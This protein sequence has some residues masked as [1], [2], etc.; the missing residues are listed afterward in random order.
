MGIFSRIF[1]ALFVIVAIPYYWLLI[2]ARTASVPAR[3]I[4][5]GAIRRAAAQ[6]DGARPTAI[7]FAPVAVRNMPGTVLVAGGGLR[8]DAVA[9]LAF[10]LATPGGDT[11]IDAGPTE[12]QAEDLGFDAFN[13]SARKAV[14]RWM[15]GARR[16]V[17]THEHPEFVGAFLTSPD[18]DA[19]APKAVLNRTQAETM[20]RMRRGTLGHVG[21]IVDPNRIVAVAP[22]IVLI[23]A[24][25]HSRGSQLIYVQLANG[26]EYLFVGDTASMRR[27]VTWQRPRSRL[28]SSWQGG[29]DRDAVIG[30][31]KGLAALQLREPQLT[32][33]YGSDLAW[34]QSP[35]HG[36]RFASAFR[37]VGGDVVPHEEDPTAAMPF[38]SNK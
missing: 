10:R 17:F 16:I 24:P 36:P 30:W 14:D 29:E 38:D 34:L 35:T 13:P 23:P 20:D 37:Y 4:D 28:A 5:I 19:I 11:I 22:G 21:P 9:K 3:S 15:R 27:N 8:P 33:V 1:I 31:I 2:D 26:R 7:T 6:I 32:V 18:F 25:G 12:R